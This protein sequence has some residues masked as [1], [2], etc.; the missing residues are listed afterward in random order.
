MAFFELC[1]FL[2]LLLCDDQAFQSA[3]DAF[4]HK[5]NAKNARRPNIIVLLAD[6]F[7][8]G[9][10]SFKLFNTNHIRTPEIKA[11]AREGLAMTK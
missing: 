6:D 3:C 11:M 1:T 8:Y 4:P 2:I 10:L 5:R 9:D 7:G